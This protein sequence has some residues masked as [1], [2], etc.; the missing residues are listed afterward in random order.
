M[1]STASSLMSYPISLK[2][3]CLPI[4]AVSTHFVDQVSSE[5]VARLAYKCEADVW[6]LRCV[7]QVLFFIAAKD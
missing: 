1:Q 7:M 3:K 4:P 2:R 6:V 5:R